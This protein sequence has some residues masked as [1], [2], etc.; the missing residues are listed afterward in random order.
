MN[1]RKQYSPGKDPWLS[2]SLRKQER[3]LETKYKD[4]YLKIFNFSDDMVI[5]LNNTRLTANIEDC[6]LDI[7]VTISY[8][9]ESNRVSIT[10][11]FNKVLIEY[12]PI[13]ENGKTLSSSF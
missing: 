9:P 3:T 1:Y 2:L 6:V 13:N 8:N 5:N 11:E 12:L 7:T 10:D 4:A